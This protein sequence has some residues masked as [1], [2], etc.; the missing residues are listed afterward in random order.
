MTSTRTLNIPSSYCIITSMEGIKNEHLCVGYII[1]WEIG[2]H[3]PET[4][5][6]KLDGGVLSKELF[7]ALYEVLGDT[8]GPC[9]DE[10][11]FRLPDFGMRLEIG[12]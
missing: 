10:G 4:S 2:Q 1:P 5:T 7:P 11:G 8:Y 12:P 3:F 9:E 6:A